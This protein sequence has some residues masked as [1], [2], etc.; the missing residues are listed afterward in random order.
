V[1]KAFRENETE[2][3]EETAEG[4]VSFVAPSEDFASSAG[5]QGTE[6]RLL[7]C[8]ENLTEDSQEVLSTFEVNQ[9]VTWINSFLADEPCEP[10]VFVNNE[11]LH[12]VLRGIYHCL[13]GHRAQENFEEAIAQ[14]FETTAPLRIHR[15][16]L[17]QIIQ[18]IAYLKPRSAKAIVDQ[19]LVARSLQGLSRKGSDLHTE[20]LVARSHYATSE[21]FLNFIQNSSKEIN[22]FG[23]LLS[24]LRALASGSD[25]RVY[26]FLFRFIPHL[27]DEISASQLAVMLQA[28]LEQTSYYHFYESYLENTV[29]EDPD[30]Q[31]DRRKLE[32]F[33]AEMVLPEWRSGGIPAEDP[34][35][36]LLLALLRARD[37]FLSAHELL[38]IARLHR[39]VDSEWPLVHTLDQAYIRIQQWSGET[40]W[41]FSPL[42]PFNNHYLSRQLSVIE[43]QGQPAQYDSEVESTVELIFQRVRNRYESRQKTP[44]AKGASPSRV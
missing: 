17:Y 16:K 34:Y 13:D 11:E 38:S 20:L 40:P 35:A 26:P 30:A 27:D 1:V 7:R 36:I 14:I 12:L 9:W 24:C 10:D 37:H 29:N 21:N 31:E 42:D 39:L 28:L 23:Y 44:I 3:I 2:E 5:F 18:I 8:P 25:S 33:L 19:E 4:D 41:T 32:I 6:E 15:E 22:D 43:A